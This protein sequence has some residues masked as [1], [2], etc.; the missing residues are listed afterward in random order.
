VRTMTDSRTVT[1]SRDDLVLDTSRCLRTRFSES[2]CRRCAVICPHEAVA[3]EDGLSIDTRRCRGCLLCTAV[4]PTGALEPNDDFSA[5]LARLSG[6]SEAVLGCIRTREYSNATVACLGALSEEHLLALCHSTAGSLT[7]NLSLCGDCPNH[8]ATAELKHRLDAISVARLTCSNCRIDLAESAQAIHYSDESVDRRSFFKSFGKA[9]FKSADIV[10][11]GA[12]KD[13]ERSCGYAEK[14]LPYRRELLNSIR[15]NFSQKLLVSSQKHFDTCLV[16][17][18]T[19]TM[20]QGC[21]AICPTGALRTDDSDMPPLFD[22]SL[23][24]GC[25]LCCE[26]CIDGALTIQNDGQGIDMEL[27]PQF[28]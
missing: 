27:G 16:I 7:L 5:S 1:G 8:A 23:C 4:C 6:L 22:K 20:C 28:P 13:I 19:C 2:A 12:N 18:D 25:G 21:V 11:S 24:T 14:R 15:K 17:G 3:L 9:L 10:L 26:F